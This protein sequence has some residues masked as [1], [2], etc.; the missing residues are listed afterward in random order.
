MTEQNPNALSEGEAKENVNS[1]TSDEAI[2]KMG[3]QIKE[4]QKKVDSHNEKENAKSIH[5]EGEENKTL[6]QSNE[7]NFGDSKAELREMV[8]KLMKSEKEQGSLADIR[9]KL[10]G[11][12]LHAFNGMISDDGKTPEEAMS[13]INESNTSEPETVSTNT[14]NSITTTT[15]EDDEKA[16]QE[17]K[18]KSASKGRSYY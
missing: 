8:V 12:E 14:N 11:M 9:S 16:Y 18:Q 13:V 17:A 10:T 1:S 2:V 3:E 7:E 15:P 5:Q 6:N 4:L